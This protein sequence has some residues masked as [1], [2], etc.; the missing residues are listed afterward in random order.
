[1]DVIRLLRSLPGA[2]DVRH[3]LGPG[4]PTLRF[5]IDDVV[6][7][8]YGISRADVGQA[9]Y[10][11]TRGQA[12]GELYLREDPIPVV[13]RSAAGEQLAVADL[14]S[15]DVPTVA[16]QVVPL[17]QVAHIAHESAGDHRPGGNRRQ[18]CNCA[19]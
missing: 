17:A 19:A 1:M 2:K 11:R 4:A 7:G 15:I 8:R 10:G 13:I 16:G 6:A 14:E 3:D 9:I 5:R 18:Q 12:V